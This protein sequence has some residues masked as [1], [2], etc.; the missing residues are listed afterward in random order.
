MGR[1][2]WSPR[3]LKHG[4]EDEE[5]DLGGP[6]DILNKAQTDKVKKTPSKINGSGQGV[7]NGEG[8]DFILLAS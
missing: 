4:L 7:K 2:F 5:H 1:Q 8:S 6:I 3:Y